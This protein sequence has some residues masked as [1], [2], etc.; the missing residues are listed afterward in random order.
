M[1][2]LSPAALAR[3]RVLAAG[4]TLPW[5]TGATFA[6]NEIGPVKPPLAAPPLKLTGADGKPTSLPALMKGRT[7]ALQLMFTG[8]SATC[9]IQGA[10]FAEAQQKLAGKT[11]EFQLLSISI[12][13]LG[14]DAKAL[15]GWLQQFGAD[16]GRWRAAVPRVDD[17]DG[18][19]DF[20][21]GRAAGPD[22]HTAQVYLFNRRA[23]LVFRTPDFPSGE[24]LVTTLQQLAARD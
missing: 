21:R 15:R 5:W 1:N 8:C 12:D 10:V 19:F 24:V 20:L 18:L 4:A 7:T 11:A 23:E 13:P 14:D 2:M 9:P 16:P 3:R 17:V 22:R 6:H